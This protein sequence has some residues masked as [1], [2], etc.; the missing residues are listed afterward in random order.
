MYIDSILVVLHNVIF[1]GIKDC[2]LLTS[3]S[4][5]HGRST[6]SHSGNRHEGAFVNCILLLHLTF[7]VSCVA[8]LAQLFFASAVI[9]MSSIIVFAQKGKLLHR[10]CKLDER[11]WT[12]LNAGLGD[13]YHLEH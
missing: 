2:S 7:Q 4:L 3:T 1:P 8:Y 9:N 11:Y 12:E 10:W 5:C 6:A 13:F